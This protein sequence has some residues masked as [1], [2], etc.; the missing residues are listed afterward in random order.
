M[1]KRLFQIVN[2]LLS[3]DEFMTASVLANKLDVST[4]TVR[5][6][7]N[8]LEPFVRENKMTLVRQ[9]GSGYKIE[10]SAEYRLTLM[11]RFINYQSSEE[12]YSPTARLIF[13]TLSTL[14]TGF[15]PKESSQL[16]K[17]LF[18]SRTTLANDLKR[19]MDLLKNFKLTVDHED[20]K[21]KGKEKNIRNCMVHCL[22]LADGYRKFTD[23]IFNETFLYKEEM[24]F[25]G[26][27]MV[28]DD[29]NEFIEGLRKNQSGFKNFGAMGFSKLLI[30]LFTIWLRVRQGHQVELSSEFIQELEELPFYV[31]AIQIMSSFGNSALMQENEVRYLQVYLFS[32]QRNYDQESHGS[33]LHQLI[34]IQLIDYWS[35]MLDL[36]FHKVPYLLENLETHLLPAVTRYRH[37]IHIENPLLNKIKSNYLAEYKLIIQSSSIVNQY[38]DVEIGEDELSFFVP[39]LLSAVR[40][41]YRKLNT[42]LVC[43]ADKGT[44]QFLIE[45][46]SFYIPEIS[47]I[48]GLDCPEIE[49]HVL[50]NIDLI[51]TTSEKVF[52]TEIPVIQIESMM[53]HENIEVLQRTIWD[54]YEKRNHLNF[55]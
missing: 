25:P 39:Y 11:N 20:L 42:L 51:L 5:N 24:I 38:F 3:T 53:I 1:K 8:E 22:I 48:V 15:Y 19:M 47:L 18:V 30:Q 37:D 14:V 7:L 52:L 13:L 41:F 36:D 46:L 10:G 2:L 4:K 26:L 55:F 40:F 49:Q 6:D 33:N 29:I 17:T 44:K 16:A 12:Q 45:N 54:L 21:L 32:S 35:D 43:D 27:S 28:S 31:E 34:A 50:E 23:K 9:P